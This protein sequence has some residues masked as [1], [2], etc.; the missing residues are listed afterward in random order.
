LG[1]KE[2]TGKEKF[3]HRSINKVNTA[4]NLKRVLKKRK[5]PFGPR[6]SRRKKRRG[7]KGSGIGDIGGPAS[8]FL[9]DDCREQKK[10]Q[11][12]NCRSAGKNAPPPSMGEVRKEEGK[13]A[14]ENSGH[15]SVKVLTSEL[16]KKTSTLEWSSEEKKERGSVVPIRGR[17]GKTLGRKGG[18]KIFTGLLR[19]R[20]GPR[21]KRS[22]NA[23]E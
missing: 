6:G 23:L 12:E 20:Y 8:V 4:K 22:L 9:R 14:G 2:K 19:Q 15:Y 13:R 3:S 1:K 7:K 5:D 11:E 18:G 10:F 21:E 17:G 16:V